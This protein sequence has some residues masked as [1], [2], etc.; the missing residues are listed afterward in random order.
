MVCYDD[1]GRRTWLPVRRRTEGPATSL[2]QGARHGLRPDAPWTVR[3]HP[4]PQG[5]QHPWLWSCDTT[6]CQTGG[7][8]VNEGDA[9]QQAAEHHL[10]THT[11]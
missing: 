1:T 7:P 11:T 4:E 8:A 6:G 9:H 2:A 3:A 10:N 5:R